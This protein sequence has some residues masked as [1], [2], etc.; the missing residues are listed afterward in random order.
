ML[1]RAE[2]A[3]L[4]VEPG[5]VLAH[6]LLVAPGL[7]G[8]GRTFQG[9][10]QGLLPRGLLLDLPDRALPDFRGGD[11]VRRRI[12]GDPFEAVEDLAG[13]R[14]EPTQHGAAD[15]ATPDMVDA[16]LVRSN[17]V[18]SRSSSHGALRACHRTQHH[19]N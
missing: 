12:D 6:G 4:G 3:A 2:R 9:S 18:L 1:S 11:V 14:I 8:R 13:E 15:T 17:D 19:L 10:G 5:L 7:A 16:D